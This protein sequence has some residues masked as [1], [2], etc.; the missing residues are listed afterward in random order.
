M[1]LTAEQ[2]IKRMSEEIERSEDALRAIN[3]KLRGYYDRLEIIHNQFRRRT[4][5]KD[6]EFQNEFRATVLELKTLADESGEFWQQTRTYFRTLDDKADVIESNRINI[7]Q[8]NIT[9]LAFNR[10]VDEL[11]TIFKNI[12][13]LAKEVPL[14]LNWWLLEEACEDLNKI[15]TRILFLIRDMG[16]YL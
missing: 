1:S 16:K 12:Q 10:Q 4:P 13:T 8:M 11:Y 6:T 14:R 15:V 5:I 2:Q 3:A 7:K 9:A